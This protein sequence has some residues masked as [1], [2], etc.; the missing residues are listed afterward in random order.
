MRTT[1]NSDRIGRAIGSAW[2]AAYLWEADANHDM[3]VWSWH[4]LQSELD[5]MAALLTYMGQQHIAPQLD[6]ITTLRDIAQ[7]HEMRAR[8]NRAAEVLTM[9]AKQARA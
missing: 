8:D 3:A 1:I 4:H 9:K 7:A 2:A 6:D 5:G